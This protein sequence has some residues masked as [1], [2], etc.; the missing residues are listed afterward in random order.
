MRAGSVGVAE[1]ALL[2]TEWAQELSMLRTDSHAPTGGPP[3]LS[4][5]R[6]NAPTSDELSG[7]RTNA[8]PSDESS[9][10]RQSSA[11]TVESEDP[12]SPSRIKR[13]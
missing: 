2:R 7:L 5:L 9:A 11:P 12:L 4:M 10:T 6:T 13:T 3:E 1:M 8:P